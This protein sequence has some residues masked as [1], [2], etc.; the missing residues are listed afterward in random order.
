MKYFFKQLK[1][2]II[3]FFVYS[4]GNSQVLKTLE[5]DYFDFKYLIEHDVEEVSTY[6]AKKGFQFQTVSKG[7][8][9]DTTVWSFNRNVENDSSIAFI[10]KNCS[11]P[12]MGFIWF[13]TGDVRIFEGIKKQ[14][15][16]L[17]FHYIG[18]ETK[19]NQLISYF[20]GIRFKM[21]FTSGIHPYSNK[22]FYIIVLEMNS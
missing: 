18:S 12:N 4:S 22:N 8:T 15:K 21:K 7:E 2:I 10:S 5:L 11:H 9:C 6:I 14:S 17:G 13:Q 3:L 16:E 19:D 20:K 1:Y